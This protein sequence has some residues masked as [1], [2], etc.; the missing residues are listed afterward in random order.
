MPPA[1]RNLHILIG[2]LCVALHCTAVAGSC[3]C[4]CPPDATCPPTCRACAHVAARCDCETH[5][6]YNLDCSPL[7]QIAEST[8]GCWAWTVRRICEKPCSRQTRRCTDCHPAYFGANCTRQCPGLLAPNASSPKDR[9]PCTGHGTCDSG[10]AGTGVC[11]CLPHFA[12][13]ACQHAV[14]NVSCG[15]AGHLTP[16]GTCDCDV[17][18][19]GPD[20]Q[21]SDNKTCLG[22]GTATET[23]GC[24]CHGGF[25]GPHCQYS[26][27]ETCSGR[28]R[29]DEAGHCTCYAAYFGVRCAQPCPGL[30]PGTG[31]A[32][33]DQI[34]CCGHGH[35]NAGVRGNGACDCFPEFSGPA[36]QYEAVRPACGG[37][38]SLTA[39]GTCRCN[40]GFAGPDCQYS[41]R[42]T[43]LG[44]GAATPTGGCRCH[45]GF[46]GSHCQYS[47][48]ETCSG[49]GHVDEVGHCVCL[50]D[51]VAGHWDGVTC[52]ECAGQW[53]G[54]GC[55]E[56]AVWLWF[57]VWCASANWLWI[58]VVPLGLC[59]ALFFVWLR[60]W[61]SGLQAGPPQGSAPN[62]GSS[63]YTDPPPPYPG[64]PDP[65]AGHPPQSPSHNKCLICLENDRN[66]I[67]M[68]CRHLA[69]CHD[70]ATSQQRCPICRQTITRREHV[71]VP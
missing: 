54:R 41:D 34:P 24:L 35:C 9:V 69:C 45:G 55:Q 65:G 31:P 5:C 33:R 15:G 2:A 70:C 1:P 71:F 25:R 44:H 14:V 36:C 27:A 21:Y 38:G 20:C 58:A 3:D 23:G 49:H 53:T 10:P 13:S 32:P 62:D 64:A 6:G 68:E 50:R 40:G 63:Q 60:A 30:L 46:N 7:R 28:G 22:R 12:G 56:C 43:C 17:G 4:A 51:N 67:F 61:V 11:R 66:C 19:A 26:D 16:A 29:V 42:T 59:C 48:A 47:D 39:S 8:R 37:Q 57:G 52:S 18:F